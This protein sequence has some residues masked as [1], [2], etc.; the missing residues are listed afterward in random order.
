[1]PTSKA[2]SP[3]IGVPS[4]EGSLFESVTTEFS[5]NDISLS[6]A[7]ILKQSPCVTWILNVRSKGFDFISDNTLGYFGYE[8]LHYVG[9]GHQFHENSMHPDDAVNIVKLNGFISEVLNQ[10]TPESRSGYKFSYDYRIIKPNGRVAHILEQNTILRQDCYGNIT[11][12][13]GS[14]TDISLWKKNGQ[15]LASLISEDEKQYFL[16]TPETKGFKHQSNL[17]K[18]ELEILHLLAEGRGSKYIADKLFI[19]F[20]TVNTHRQKMIKKTDTKNTGGL[21]QFAVF[22]GLI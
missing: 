14:C 8:H 9:R 15:Q 16:F 17:S 13:L 18:R 12:L 10:V 20:H 21:V 3:I 5:F 6:M 2:T 7:V 22:N 19:S 11:H 4:D 1:M